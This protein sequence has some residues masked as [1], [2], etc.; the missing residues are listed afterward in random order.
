MLQANISAAQTPLLVNTTSPVLAQTTTSV[1]LPSSPSRILVQ[2][3]S[4]ADTTNLTEIPADVQSIDA[5]VNSTYLPNV[6]THVLNLDNG[7]ANASTLVTELRARDGKRSQFL[8]SV[9]SL[10]HL[11]TAAQDPQHPLLLLEAL[12]RVTLLHAV[13]TRHWPPVDCIYCFE[14]SHGTAVRVCCPCVHVA[15]SGRLPYYASA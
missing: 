14:L 10:A 7:T 1:T 4:L 15:H 8:T 13:W 6:D 2:F 12:L 5:V 9:L 3:N 11:Q